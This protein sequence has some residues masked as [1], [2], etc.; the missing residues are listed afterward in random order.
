MKP[1]PIQRER[2]REIEKSERASESE[3]YNE[4]AS[5]RASERARETCVR[6]I[7]AGMKPP[8]PMAIITSG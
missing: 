2:A 8:P 4:R 5:K 6:S 3:K 1:P 7:R